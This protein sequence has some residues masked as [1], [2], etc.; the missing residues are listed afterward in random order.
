[1]KYLVEVVNDYERLAEYDGL[2]TAQPTLNVEFGYD[3]T[4]AIKNSMKF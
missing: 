3:F 1:M 2:S 4:F